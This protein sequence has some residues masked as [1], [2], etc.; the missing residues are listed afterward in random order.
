[1]EVYEKVSTLV[2]IVK[3]IDKKLI[4][5]HTNLVLDL[6]ADSLDMSECKSVI[7]SNFSEASNPPITRIKTV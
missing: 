1:M 6:H 2:A 4:Y 3:K 5:F 7:Q